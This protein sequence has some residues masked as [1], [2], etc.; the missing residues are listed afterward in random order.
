ML[1]FGG[2]VALA[3]GAAAIAAAPTKQLLPTGQEITPTA[4]PG[5]EFE[6]LVTRNGPHPS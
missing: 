4:A 2:I 3:I 5:A 1:R 6:P